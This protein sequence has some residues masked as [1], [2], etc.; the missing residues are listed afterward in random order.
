MFSA[1]QKK[2]KKNYSQWLA[3]CSTIPHRRRPSGAQMQIPCSVLRPLRRPNVAAPIMHRISSP[4]RPLLSSMASRWLPPA[5]ARRLDPSLRRVSS[6][7]TWGQDVNLHGCEED[8]RSASKG[9]T[10]EIVIKEDEEEASDYEYNLGNVLEKSRHRDG[11]IYRAMRWGW[12]MDY[13]IGDRSES[14]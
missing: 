9:R 12:K 1:K 6:E 11:S 8:P 10:T 2:K 3:Q 4:S 5:L 13:P 14:N 7:A